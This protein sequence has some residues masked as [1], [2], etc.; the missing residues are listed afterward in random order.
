MA[1]KKN[2]EWLSIED[3]L[4]EADKVNVEVFVYK[5]KEL[6]V[7]W[8]ELRMEESPSFSDFLDSAAPDAELSTK[9]MMHIGE[10]VAEMLAFKMI[11]KG[12]TTSGKMP[13]TEEQWNKLPLTLRKEIINRVTASRNAT[14]A[15]F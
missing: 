12:Q 8:Q 2:E 14:N 10:K 7:Q 9:D 5:G 6:V 15:R 4:A 1:K 3:L 11:V 13:W